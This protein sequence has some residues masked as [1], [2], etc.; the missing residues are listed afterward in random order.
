M[1][2]IYNNIASDELV[3]LRKSIATVAVLASLSDDGK[4]DASEKEAAVKL[5]QQRTYTSPDVL[6]DFYT[7]VQTN[8]EADIEQQIASLPQGDAEA[9]KDFLRT[10]LEALD[11]I[12]SKLSSEFAFQF[13]K[14]QETFA[15]VVFKAN[16]NIFMNFFTGFKSNIK[17]R[18][19]GSE[20]EE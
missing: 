7:E 8:I 11:P 6:K 10:E 18:V 14:S 1:S 16:D 5:S 17:E 20:E 15:T 13:A 12:L 9:Q 3:T 4:I 2:E 19:F